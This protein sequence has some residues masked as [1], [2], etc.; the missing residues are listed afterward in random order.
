MSGR[1]P[2]LR[3]LRIADWETMPPALPWHQAR[4]AWKTHLDAC[5]RLRRQTRDSA[6]RDVS[7]AISRRISCQTPCGT[8][9]SRRMP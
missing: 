5:S 4:R 8:S 9:R 2:S 7:W 1:N 6:L 3:L